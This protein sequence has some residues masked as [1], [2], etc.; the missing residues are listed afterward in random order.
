MDKKQKL[1]NDILRNA[2]GL[3]QAGQHEAA[4]L[5]EALSDV[6]AARPAVA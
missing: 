2:V 4:R 1:I 3:F 6:I 5:A